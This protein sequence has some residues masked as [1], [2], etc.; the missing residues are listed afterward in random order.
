MYEISDERS[1]PG[2]MLKIGAVNE[3]LDI[4]WAHRAAALS[5]WPALLRNMQTETRPA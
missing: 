2:I 4:A 1:R 5:A 3:L